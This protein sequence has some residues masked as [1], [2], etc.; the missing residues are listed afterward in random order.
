MQPEEGREGRGEKREEKRRKEK[1]EKRY[2]AWWL[3]LVI[4]ALWEAKLDGLLE[5]RSLRIAWPTW[6]NPI[7]TK[8][9]KINQ[10]WWW[11]PVIPAN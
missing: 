9:V 2:R 10:A 1:K 3:M 7:S 8:N 6:G 4:S 5:V 11:A